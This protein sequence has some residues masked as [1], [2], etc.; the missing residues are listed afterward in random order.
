M[1]LT[2]ARLLLPDPVT[3]TMLILVLFYHKIASLYMFIFSQAGPG[4][5]F[6]YFEGRKVIIRGWS[7]SDLI[8]Y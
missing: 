5:P 6:S 2:I 1:E 4:V 3:L 8:T 7:W